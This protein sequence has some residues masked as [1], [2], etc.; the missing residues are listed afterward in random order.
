MERHVIEEQ[1]QDVWQLALELQRQGERCAL[2][3]LL[4]QATALLAQAWAITKECDP[5]LA[6][7]AAW[8]IGWLLVRMGSYGEAAKWFGHVVAPPARESQLWPAARQALV[9]CCQELVQKPPR[10]VARPVLPSP[11]QPVSPPDSRPSDMP[12]LKV[13]NLG[14]FQLVRAGTVLPICTAHKAIAIFRYLLTQRHRAAPKEELMNLLWP[15]ARPLAA[16]HS[17][18]V[19]V[20]TLRAHLDPSVGSYLLFQG[21]CYTINPDAPVED[22]CKYF[23]HR[24]DEAEG[25]RRANDLVRAQQ[26]YTDAIACYQGD[27]YLDNQDFTWV[28]AEQERLL[29][30]YLLALEHLG[31]IFMTQQRFEAAAE[32]YQRLLERDGYREDV[33]CHLMRCYWQLG[34]RGDALRQYERCA[35][36]IAN[37]LGLEPM[38]ETQALYHAITGTEGG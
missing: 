24:C 20:S 12:L 27:Y 25:Y 37:D 36:I 28:I 13:K 8:D 9:Q 1:I 6:N 19:A 11:M 18:H 3:G 2:A 31:H 21:G 34:R 16:A 38:Q 7:T 23:Q 14:R 26:A 33:H 15:D 35:T 4:E 10:L 30:R 17:L 32:C 22:D 29:A 5:D